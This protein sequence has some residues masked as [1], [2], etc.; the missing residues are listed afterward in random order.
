MVYVD[1]NPIRAALADTPEDS[2]FTSIQ[3]R[4]HTWQNETM[5]MLSDS[6]STDQNILSSSNCGNLV[7]APA[8]EPISNTSPNSNSMPWLCPISSDSENPGILSM[9]T[10]EY[11]DLVDRSGR[12]SK[13]GKLGSIDAEIAPNLQ[14][15]GANPDAWGETIS[16]FIHNSTSPVKPYFLRLYL[17]AL[18]RRL[19]FH[20]TPDLHSSKQHSVI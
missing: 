2:D 11:F 15:I 4:I 5:Q 7:S 12:M 19:P 13:S 9:T 17:I 10:A 18:G 6:Q 16:H 20:K 1:L 8:H 14:R 3:E